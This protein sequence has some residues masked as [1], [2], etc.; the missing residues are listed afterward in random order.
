MHRLRASA[1]P[2]AVSA[3]IRS[4]ALRAPLPNWSR[5][6]STRTE[7][8][9]CR[10]SL[11]SRAMY[12]S[13]SFISASIS[14]TGRFQFSWLNAKRVSTPTPAW[15]QPS[16]TSRTAFIPAWWPSGRGSERPLAQRPFPSMMM[17]IWP[18]T[19]PCR[20]SRCSRS[21]LIRSDFQDLRFL[22]VNQALDLLDVVV[23]ELLN[24][25]L[26]VAL[27]VLRDFLEL[28]HLG[29]RLG[30][31]MPHGDAT[32]LAQLVDDFDEVPPPLFGE[33]RQR[34]PDEVAL[35]CRVESQIR[36]ADGF[37]DGRGERLVEGLNGEEP[38]LGRGDHGDLVER[39]VTAVRLDPDDVEQRAAG[40]AAS[41]GTEL[42]LRA[43]DRL[44]HQVSRMLGQLGNGAH[45]TMVP[46]RSPWSTREMAPGWLMLKTMIGSWLALHSPN[47]LAS[48][49]A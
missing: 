26:R 9:C 31:G 38:R 32:L 48:M 15:R 22:R 25:F 19:A 23:S 6:P 1:S 44:L 45:R 11:A 7:T 36:F 8:P 21:L 27:I 34:H 29:E 16:T 43:L 30:A 33:R 47:A 40:L 5:W 41:D 35:G 2:P 4:T 14:P 28:L 17:A 12:S 46:T 18:G 20:R 37:L 49:T 39:H 24:V 10:R 3:M 42:A 13:S